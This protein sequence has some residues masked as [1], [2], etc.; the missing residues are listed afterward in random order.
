MGLGA[1]EG[2]NTNEAILNVI[3]HCEKKLRKL[4]KG[5]QLL[6]L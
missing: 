4:S 1:K 5:F 3:R 6:Q 2:G